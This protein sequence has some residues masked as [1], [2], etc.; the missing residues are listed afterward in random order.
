MF[1]C[2]KLL[3]SLWETFSFSVRNFLFR[4]GNF[5]ETF[6][7]IFIPFMCFPLQIMRGIVARAN[8]VRVLKGDAHKNEMGNEKAH[9]TDLQ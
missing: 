6:F 2:E 3:V 9:K 7:P 1:R 8:P 4:T 5:D